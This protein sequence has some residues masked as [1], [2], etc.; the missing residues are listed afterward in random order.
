M[1]MSGQCTF[2]LPKPAAVALDI[3]TRQRQPWEV[4]VEI[5][6]DPHDRP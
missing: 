1:H 4:A 2:T 6:A 5:M 3:A